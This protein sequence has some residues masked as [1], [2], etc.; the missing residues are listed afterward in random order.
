MDSAPS[1]SLI[2]RF[3]RDGQEDMH[4]RTLEDL[5][6]MRD[7][8]MES[9]HDHIQW[10]FP[11][12]EESAY[13]D[14]EVISAQDMSELRASDLAKSNMIRSIGRFR[15]FLGLPSVPGEPFKENKIERWCHPFDHNLLRITRVIRSARIFGLEEEAA[16]FYHDVL[17]TARNKQVGSTTLR[18]WKRA[19]EEDPMSPLNDVVNRENGSRGENSGCR[20]S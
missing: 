2:V 5:I 13:R 10:M 14:C 16:S 15:D 7:F 1:G 6:A 4:G 9:C 3:Y 11:L 17:E 19:A 20:Q 12:H 18:Y 8:E